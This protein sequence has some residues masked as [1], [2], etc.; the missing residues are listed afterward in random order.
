[1]TYS[2][3]TRTAQWR[4]VD[5]EAVL[6]NTESSYYYSLNRS[7]TLVWS[8]LSEGARSADDLAREVATAFGIDETR[9]RHDVD[10]LLQALRA[11]DLVLES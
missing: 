2:V 5:G 8:A 9:A 1:M 11:E 3:N 7:G 10:T 4:I 6:V